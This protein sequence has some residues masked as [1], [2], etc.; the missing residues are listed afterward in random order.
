MAPRDVFDVPKM[1]KKKWSDEMIEI[2][3]AGA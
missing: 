3:L 1:K 2:L